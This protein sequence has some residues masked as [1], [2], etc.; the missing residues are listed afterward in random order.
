[1]AEKKEITFTGMMKK[2]GSSH[3]I[4]VPRNTRLAYDIT[5]GDY[6]LITLIHL[7]KE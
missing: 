5:D 3:M 4:A 7:K 6:F 2:I 1:M